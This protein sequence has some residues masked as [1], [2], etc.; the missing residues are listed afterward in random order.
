MQST[1][2]LRGRKEGSKSYAHEAS[3]SNSKGNKK[4]G[5][6]SI[7]SVMRP[8]CNETTASTFPEGRVDEWINTSLCCTASFRRHRVNRNI[9]CHDCYSGTHLPP[10][11]IYENVTR[12][13]LHIGNGE[14]F[15]ICHMCD[16]TI[17]RVRVSNNCI[18]CRAVATDFVRYLHHSHDRPFDSLE[19]TIIAITEDRSW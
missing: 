19:P 3:S 7:K 18:V 9:V 5:I 14:R 13:Y 8:P 17:P 16:A 1:H 2:L 15:E 10:R 11:G 4:V 6:F 12:H